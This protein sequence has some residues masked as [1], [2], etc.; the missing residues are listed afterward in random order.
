MKNKLKEKLRNGEVTYGI[1]VG[2]PSNDIVE[3]AS[4]LAFDWIWFDG[5][6]GP[7]N[8]EILHPM[9]QATRAGTSPRSSVCRGTTWCI[10]R[11][12]W[13]SGRKA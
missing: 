11:R 8:A 12:R 2:T 4:N 6:H 13:T 9:I 7:L 1:S 3:L 10:S 5:E